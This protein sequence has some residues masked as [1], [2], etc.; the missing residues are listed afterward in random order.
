MR[1]QVIDRL[2]SLALARSMVEFSRKSPNPYPARPPSIGGGLPLPPLLLPVS[3]N[4]AD[5]DTNVPPPVS[6]TG[7]TGC[8]TGDGRVED[9]RTRS[10]TGS[11]ERIERLAA[12]YR[13]IVVPL[14]GSE[15]AEWA[16]P[17]GEELARI[18]GVPL[19]LIRVVDVV[20][21]AGFPMD[22][23]AYSDNLLINARQSEEIAAADYLAELQERYME[24]PLLVTIERRIGRIT[25]ELL[26]A[27]RDGDLYVMASHGRG[28]VSR[29]FLGSVAEELT[30][31]SRVPVMVIR[32]QT[33]KHG[34]TVSIPRV[35]AHRR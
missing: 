8:R 1:Y 3:V 26:S 11:W 12:M 2:A 13:R 6:I 23:F 29:L 20:S 14:D 22:D 16:L 31:H 33:A 17:H 24:Q 15:L 7:S 19:H 25:Q 30:R 5:V 35:A 32:A 18:I 21:T 10:R 27:A 9:A 34:H 28:G 4:A